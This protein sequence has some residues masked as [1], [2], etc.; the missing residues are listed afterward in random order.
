MATRSRRTAGDGKAVERFEL[1]PRGPYALAASVRFLEGFA[2]AAYESATPGH[3][4]LAFVADGGAAVAG[5]CVRAEG[6][7]VAG[8]IVGE[9]DPGV[10]RAQV[11]RI[12]SL[13]VDGSGFPA[14]GARDPVIGRLQAHYPGLRPVLFYSPYEAAAWALI[15]HRIRITQA[16]RIK[17]RM[18]EEVGPAV[19]V[20]GERLHAFPGPARLADLDAVP[21]LPTQKVDRLRSLGRAAAGG[22]L[23][24]AHLRALPPA[25]AL[26]RLKELP[27][28]GDFSAQLILLRGAGEPDYL[29]T[30]EPRLGRAVA[31]AY[32]LDRPPTATKLAALAEAWRPYRTWATLLL[33]AMLEDD[34]HEIAGGARRSQGSETEE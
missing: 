27:G 9:A 28:I 10:V 6:G 19:M 23:D 24:A 29:P 12:L 14:V 21:G 32:G 13:D 16:A 20:H 8:E 15:G 18:A 30:A 26:A 1:H 11:A 7:V 17:A 5:V 31:R 4:H 22:A 25:E 2:P 34:T 3:L 33:R